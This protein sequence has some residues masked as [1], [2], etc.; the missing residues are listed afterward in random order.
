MPYYRENIHLLNCPSKTSLPSLLIN[1]SSNKNV[2]SERKVPPISLYKLDVKINDQQN[3]HLT[4]ADINREDTHHLNNSIY[5]MEQK[6]NDILEVDKW[7]GDEIQSLI[8]SMLDSMNL[9]D[10]F[11]DLFPN[12]RRYTWHSRGKSSIL[13]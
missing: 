9:T 4:N 2:Y 11:R 6:D 10:C 5:S 3:I 1:H 13:D 12:I 8:I 7:F